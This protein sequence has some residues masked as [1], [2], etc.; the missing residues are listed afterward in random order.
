MN[1]TRGQLLI[2]F[3]LVGLLRSIPGRR[4]RLAICNEIFQGWTFGRLCAG[5]RRTGYA[6]LEI[7]P[8]TLSDDPVSL[9][10]SRRSHLRKVMEAEGVEYVGLHWL[11]STPRG[12]HV[13]TPDAAVRRRS[14]EYLRRLVDLCSDLGENGVMVFGSGKQRG[15]ILGFSVAEAVQHLKEGFAELA[16]VAESQG[17][18]ILLE[19]LAPHLCDVVNTLE[20]AVSI[21]REVKSPSLQAMF[22]VHNTVAERLSHPELIRKYIR[23]IR[24]VHINEMDG[25][26]PGSGSYDFRTLVRTLRELDYSGWVSLEVFDFTPGAEK[27]ALD[28]SRLI[29]QLEEALEES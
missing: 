15:T 2:A 1:L 4:L 26:Y 14:W 18:T 13:T 22:D 8:F 23:Q 10:P 6:G 24:H 29:R 16:P 9:P 19:P 20:E 7:A 21:V 11:L 25:R 5:A 28:S 27:I 3:P 17:V 12:L